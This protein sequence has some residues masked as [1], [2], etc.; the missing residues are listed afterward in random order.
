MNRVSW[1]SLLILLPLFLPSCIPA[2]LLQENRSVT[3]TDQQIKASHAKVTAVTTETLR[4][5]PVKK[6][7]ASP[8]PKVYEAAQ[9]AVSH[10]EAAGNMPSTLSGDTGKINYSDTEA[11]YYR[12]KDLNCPPI[13]VTIFLESK[14]P[15]ATMVYFYPYHQ[16]YRQIPPDLMGVVDANMR[17]RGGLFMYRLETQL[18]GGRK[19]AWLK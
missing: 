2:S 1:K 6:L 19:W 4:T 10:Y 5:A 14:G 11:I 15:Q 17:H 9:Q 8:L 18:A 7:V 3:L 13:T 16:L 12:K